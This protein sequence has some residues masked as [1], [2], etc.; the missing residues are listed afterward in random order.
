[1]IRER[2]IGIRVSLAAIPRKWEWAR[3]CNA[4]TRYE[5]YFGLPLYFC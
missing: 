3:T 5:V 2:K 1:V 4:G